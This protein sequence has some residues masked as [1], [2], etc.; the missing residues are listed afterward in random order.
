MG[1]GSL[2]PSHQP[3]LR[4]SLRINFADWDSSAD[5]EYRVDD[6]DLSRLE[7]RPVDGKP[8]LLYFYDPV[9]GRL[10]KDFILWDGERVRT[11]MNVTL[12][13]KDGALEPRVRLWKRSKPKSEPAV[14]EIP[15]VPATRSV[16]AAVDVGDG[17]KAFWRVIA[18]IQAMTGS[19]VPVEAF[20]LVPTEGAELAEL[21]SGQNKASLLKAMQLTIGDELTQADISMLTNRRAQLEEFRQLLEDPEYFAARRSLVRGD[22][23]VW[24]RFFERNQ[25]IFGYGLTFIACESLTGAKLEQVTT[26]HN[27]FTGAGKRSDAVMRTK[28]YLS[29]LLFGEIKTHKTD[30][31]TATAYRVPDVY[32]VSAELSGAV[33]QIQK[34]ADKA[35]GLMQQRIFAMADDS[36]TPMGVEVLTVRPRQILIIGH[37]SQLEE[38]GRFN[39]EKA[40]SFEL[41]RRSILGVEIITFDELYERAKFIVAGE[42]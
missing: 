33:S 20:R 28:G 8:N 15:D 13:K 26:G 1:L 29:S 9:L 35:V 38:N 42:A 40:H 27:I 30:L 3:G 18:F 4:G 7:I 24:Q 36:G 31:L 17:H 16:K 23:E 6:A 37:L 21:L 39:Q 22:E 32:R 5:T 41:F 25:W 34:T 2:Y 14:E 12:I 11:L 10:I 19:E